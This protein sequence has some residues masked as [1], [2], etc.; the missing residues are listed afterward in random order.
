MELFR[1]DNG[2]FGEAWLSYNAQSRKIL[3]SLRLATSA[4]FGKVLT[5][6]K[7]PETGV[8]NAPHG[9][10]SA[11]AHRVTQPPGSS[12]R[13]DEGFSEQKQHEESKEEAEAKALE[14]QKR[15]REKRAEEERKS[16]KEKE[17]QRKESTK[18]M[19][20]AQEKAKEEEIL[21]GF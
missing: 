5:A 7:L 3:A 1:P 10:A 17:Q 11:Q 16:E 4:N 20:E 18:M 13:Q 19:V 12:I 14:L 15:L 6:S 9:G 21:T 8:S 2:E